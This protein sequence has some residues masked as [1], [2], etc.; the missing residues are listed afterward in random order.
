MN[1]EQILEQLV[2]DALESDGAF[3]FRAP[4]RRPILPWVVSSLLAASVA[5]AVA[6]HAWVA[7]VRPDPLAATI[8][9]LS[10]A[11]GVEIDAGETTEMLVAWQEAPL[12]L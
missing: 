6:L 11:D 1:E 2:R 4:R 3:A 8:A 12:W 7:P 9:F 10:E 5:V